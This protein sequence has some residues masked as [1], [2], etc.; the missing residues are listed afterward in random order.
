MYKLITAAI[1]AGFLSV[2]SAL[3]TTITYTATPAGGSS[4]DAV[5][6]VTNDTLGSSIEEFTIFFDVGVFEN[7]RNAV[8]P[9]DWD[10]L[11]IDPDSGIPDDG[12]ADWLAL[13]TSLGVGE[14]LGGFGLTFDLIVGSLPDMLAFT[15]I[16]PNTFDIL[17]EGFATLINGGV[18]DVPL[19]AAMWVFLV[20]LGLLGRQQ[21]KS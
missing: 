2:G 8:S 3:A 11:L 17:D 14:T 5:F 15:I 9:T 12:F 10:P 1:V 21:I 7:L 19:P 18:S 6:E 4:F 13:G 20:G 16:D